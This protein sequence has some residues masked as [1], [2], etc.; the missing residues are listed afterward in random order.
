MPL[1]LQKSVS[2]L[3]S[4][5]KDAF[6]YYTVY[7]HIIYVRLCAYTQCCTHVLY[8]VGVYTQQP[9]LLLLQASKGLKTDVMTWIERCHP[10]DRKSHPSAGH[11]PWPSNR[12]A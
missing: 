1:R 2:K 5:T 4:T 3:D 7:A 6:L 11:R 9:M 12:T 8:I 10:G